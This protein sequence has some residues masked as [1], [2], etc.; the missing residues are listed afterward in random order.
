MNRPILPAGGGVH[1][2]SVALVRCNKEWILWRE[3]AV[4]FYFSKGKIV[5]AACSHAPTFFFKWTLT[6]QCVQQHTLTYAYQ[7]TH[8]HA[9][10]DQVVTAKIL[11]R[12]CFVC[13]TLFW[14]SIKTTIYFCH[15]HIISL[16]LPEKMT[17]C[18][19]DVMMLKKDK[20]AASSFSSWPQLIFLERGHSYTGSNHRSFLW[21]SKN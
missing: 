6:H 2:V 1:N 19:Y 15:K 11:K 16:P 20:D 14:D 3:I 9:C 4:H 17:H 7:E 10:N 5:S 12:N 18:K 21:P 8:V 13:N